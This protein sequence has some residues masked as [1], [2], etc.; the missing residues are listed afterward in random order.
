MMRAQEM[1]YLLSDNLEIPESV[2]QRIE[3]TLY[4]IR[5]NTL[6]IKSETKKSRIKPLYRKPAV[7]AAAVAIAL[8]VFSTAALAY[9]ENLREFIF[10]NSSARLVDFSEEH[11]NEYEEGFIISASS[12]GIVNRSVPDVSYSGIVVIESLD[13]SSFIEHFLSFEELQQA[14]L[15]TIK[16]PSYLPTDMKF[17]EAGILLYEDG[18][19]SY[20]VVSTYECKE[21]KKMLSFVQKYVG[22]DAYLDLQ[23]IDR[24]EVSDFQSN[25]HL[26]TVMV[27]D[28]EALLSVNS[29]TVYASEQSNYLTLSWVN[30]GVAYMLSTSDFDVETLITIAKSV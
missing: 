4:R 23:I 5:A 11:V 15:F 18:T 8:L 12:D 14:A 26:E 19:Y 24:I 10:G 17:M 28:T 21:N 13:D 9:S 25:T 30:D 29:V 16:E 20:D 7:I 27:G 1:H 3:E 2:D 6:N 22:A